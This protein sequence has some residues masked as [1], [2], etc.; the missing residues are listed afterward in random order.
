MNCRRRPVCL[1]TAVVVT[2]LI[3]PLTAEDA[4][5]PSS[6][7]VPPGFRVELLRS[8]A[9]DDGSWISM[10]FEPEGT[11][12][13]GRDDAGFARLRP[14]TDG[15]SVWSCERL[16][17]TLKHCRGVLYAHNSLFVNATDSM[18]FWRFRD[19]DGDGKYEDSKLLK[20][21]DYRSRFGHGQNQIVLGPDGL[22]YL[23]IGN[24]VAFPEGVNPRSPYLDPQKDRLLPDP[25]DAEQDDRVGYVLRT[26]PDG[27]DWVVVAGGLRNEFDAAFDA[28]GELF[29]WD[30]DMEWDV[31]LPWYRPTRLNHIVSG[32]EYGWRWGT[33]KWPADYPD[34]LPANLETGLGSPTGMVFAYD[35]KFPPKYRSR[36]LMADW[37]H[38]KILAVTL[39]PDGASYQA[40]A[41]VFV[42]GAPLNVCD[43]LV[44][45]DGALYFITGGRGSQSGLYRVS[46]DG[47]D[48]PAPS[49]TVEEATAFRTGFEARKL[50][51][52]LEVFHL[53]FPPEAI[54]EIWPYLGD[55]DRWL[56]SA[57]RIAL[58]HQNPE[59]WSARIAE[60]TDA[61]RRATAL[62]A[63]ARVSEPEQ[64]DEVQAALLDAPLPDGLE[65]LGIQLRAWSILFARGLEPSRLVA[66]HLTE[67]FA[68]LYPHPSHAINR[69]LCELLVQLKWPQ[70]VEQTL[71]LIAS[72]ASQEDEVQ[73]VHALL[74]YTG[75][76]T[77]EQRTNL[78]HPPA[79]PG[80][81]CC[82]RSSPTCDRTCSTVSRMRNARHSQR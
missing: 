43:L 75:A 11:I 71:P 12:I 31:G 27:T 29:T 82:R 22:L 40:E 45:P 79:S 41:E 58:E 46:Y 37:Q 51:K 17:D 36:L 65:P 56:R 13:V 76:W 10:T 78:L 35:S 4:T 14:P 1:I 19:L 5:P 64:R 24:D 60:E 68:P 66:R 63:W 77:P 50:R 67:R 33:A 61:L 3:R 34:S 70:I 52:R 38:G 2:F 18:E 23:I 25:H 26:D 7:T 80:D 53:P 44:G 55:A 39:L 42:E 16:N 81:I 59:W 28:D 30:A 32:G 6:I 47:P 72:A 54:E 62:L 57:A 48:E 74:R 20:S 9:P 49:P 69:D 73:Y 8:A 21:F 15:T